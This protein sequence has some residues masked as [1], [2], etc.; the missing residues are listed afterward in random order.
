MSSDFAEYL[1]KHRASYEALTRAQERRLANLYI[2]F[3]GKIKAE[4]PNIL[5]KSLASEKRIAL[6]AL[7][8][9]AAKLTDNFKSV[10]DKALLESANLGTE[11]NKYIMKKYQ[12]S[13][14]EHNLELNTKKILFKIPDDAVRITANRIWTDGLKLSDRIWKLDKTARGQIERVVME[15]ITTGRPASDPVLTRTLEGMFNPDYTGRLTTLHGRKVSYEAARILRTESRIAFMEADRLSSEA[16]PGVQV[17][18]WRR[19]AYEDCAICDRLAAEGP[20][21]PNEIPIHS[22]PNCMC[23]LEPV[24]EDIKAF[25]D[26]YLK[27][28]DNPASQPDLAE[29]MDSYGR[30][31]AA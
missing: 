23:Y 31:M 6:N 15:A 11:A 25:T 8:R 26:R 29:W 4:I 16:N 18:E 17:V 22:H 24:A 21:K 7:I 14:L 2:D 5:S 10:L 20:Y 19:G 1:K 13:L 3:A 9:E 30:K 27:F 12:A 28:M